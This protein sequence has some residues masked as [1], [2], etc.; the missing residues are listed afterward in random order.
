M[1]NC[2]TMLYNI[3]KHI[4]LD[5]RNY[6]SKY[7]RYWPC[8]PFLL[9]RYYWVFEIVS[10]L[11]NFVRC[12][13]L[14]AILKICCI[15]VIFYFH[16]I[17]PLGR[18]DHRVAMSVCVFVCLFVPFPCDFFRG[19]SLAL[20]SHDQIPASHWSAPQNSFKDFGGN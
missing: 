2:G 7:L 15:L 1:W 12:M 11:I 14:Y 13:K 16:R 18:F 10:F 9:L 19:L 3:S 17:G 6:N 8:H 4:L 5:P 20:R